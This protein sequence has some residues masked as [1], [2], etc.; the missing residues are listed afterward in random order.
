MS[1]PS[2]MSKP[3]PAPLTRPR[4]AAAV[5]AAVRALPAHAAPAE[6]A[7][8]VT[9]DPQV[10][11]ALEPMSPLESRTLRGVVVAAGVPLVVAAARLAGLEIAEGDAATIL[12]S[13]VSLA[14]AV[15]AWRGRVAAAR[16]LR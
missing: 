12:A 15:Y 11:P 4:L 7:G 6:V 2:F 3:S 8:R 14:G 10:A 13:L 1:M 9:S 16:P 5:E